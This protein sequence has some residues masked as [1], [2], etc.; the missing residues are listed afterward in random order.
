MI[1]AVV[2]QPLHLAF[3]FEQIL[4]PETNKQTNGY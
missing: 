4:L 2:E 1:F 3:L